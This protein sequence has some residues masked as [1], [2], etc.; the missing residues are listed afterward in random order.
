M[1][2]GDQRCGQLLAGGEAG[3]LLLG[4]LA[5]P[6][7]L[8][9]QLG[10]DVLDPREVRL[11]LAQLILRLAA[12][13]LVAADPGHLLEQR[14]ALLRTQRERLVDHA[15][16]DEQEGVLGEVR[17]VQEVHEVLQSDPLLVEQVVVLA[18]AVE[19]PA[20]LDHGVLDRQERVTVVEH[21][22][23][24]RHARAQRAPA[25]PDDVL[26]SCGCEARVPARRAP[27]GAHR[28]GCSCPS[29]WGRRPR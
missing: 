19:T 14:P 3:C 12:P 28:R 23:H 20:E 29:R 2:G 9:P 16:A 25:G 5:E 11:G 15:L 18:R 7:R 22:R 6:P 24:V 4:Q 21:E 10:E 26:R 13:A 1:R 17:G 8:R 27:S